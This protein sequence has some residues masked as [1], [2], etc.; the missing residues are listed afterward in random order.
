MVKNSWL[1]FHSWDFWWAK[2]SR[3]YKILT[4]SQN[5]PFKLLGVF[6]VMNRGLFF[7][8]FLELK[9]FVPLFIKTLFYLF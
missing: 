3:G 2:K 1:G 5:W 6:L 7:C 9:L 8:T 4:H